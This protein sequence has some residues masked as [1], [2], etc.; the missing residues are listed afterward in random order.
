MMFGRGGVLSVFPTSSRFILSQ[1]TSVLNCAGQV[2]MPAE[3]G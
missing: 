2:E 1:G 3:C